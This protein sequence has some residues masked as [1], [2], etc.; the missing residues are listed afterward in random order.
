LQC[1]ALKAKAAW[2]AVAWPLRGAKHRHAETL[3]GTVAFTGRGARQMKS[4][5]FGSYALCSCIAAAMLAGCGAS[6]PPIG[7][8]GAMQQTS[9]TAAHADR[10]KS[11]MLPQASSKDLLYVS[12]V[13]DYDDVEVY[14]ASGKDPS[15]IAVISGDLDTPVSDCIDG[16]G[17]L[18]VV[19]EPGGLGW[20]TEF[21]AGKTKRSKIIKRGIN[22]PAFCA[23]DG[24]GNLW[25][26]NIGA[27]NVTEYEKGSTK[28]NEIITSGLFYPD[29]VT[30]DKSGNMYVANHYTEGTKSF[31]PGNVVVYAPG[32]KSPS[33]TITDGVATPVGITV[34][35]N[36]TLYVTNITDD[37]VQEYLSGQSH[38]Y[39][40]V[41]EGIASPC[42]VAV[43]DKGYLYVTDLYRSEVVEFEPGSITPSK[44][45]ISKGLSEPCGMAYSPPLLP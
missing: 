31:A 30:I 28:P 26:T 11:W 40:T 13:S 44:R 42:T 41:T 15:P 5:G 43:S 37:N 10:G 35:A 12:N 29:G 7:A 19:N 23:I 38:P 20:V 14:H 36:D 34:D 27:Q 33:R 9:A 45:E 4:L 24:S 6:Q 3:P 8:P 1:K 22:T 32:K 2:L 21:P 16:D 39:Q 18:Y 17:T 25:V